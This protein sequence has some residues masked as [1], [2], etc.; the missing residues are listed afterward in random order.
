MYRCISGYMAIGVGLFRG[1]FVVVSLLHAPASESALY[2]PSMLTPLVLLAA[3]LF[4]QFNRNGVVLAA[5]WGWQLGGIIPHLLARMLLPIP[6][7]PPELM[8]HGGTLYVVGIEY[9]SE[10]I[11]IAITVAG[12]V[13]CYLAQ[14]RERNP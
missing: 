11:V 4:A 2:I 10:S 7:V 8:K 5:A 3:G 9:V 14:R 1:C 6:Q 12:L 13:L